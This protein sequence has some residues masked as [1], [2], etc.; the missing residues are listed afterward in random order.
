MDNEDGIRVSVHISLAL[1]TDATYSS[2]RMEL[3]LYTQPYLC[4]LPQHYNTTI[5]SKR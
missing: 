2:E 5:K 1:H 3:Y 4:I